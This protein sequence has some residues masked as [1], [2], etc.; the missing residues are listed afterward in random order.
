LVAILEELAIWCNIK[1]CNACWISFELHM[2]V[3]ANADT[4]EDALAAR[5]N[6]A[7]GIGLCR[8]EHMFFASDER[9]K[10]VRQMI[11]ATTTPQRQVALDK[12]L[13]Y[14]RSD[15]EGIFRVMDGALQCS[16]KLMLVDQLCRLA[17]SFQ[18]IFANDTLPYSYHRLLALHCTSGQQ[19]IGS[20]QSVFDVLSAGLLH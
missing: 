2:Q 9:I 1:T 5:N 8:T 6:G 12:L 7:E 15:F 13:P 18:P 3:M 16:C 17:S 4:P 10:A 14:Q 19:V 20:F 11:M